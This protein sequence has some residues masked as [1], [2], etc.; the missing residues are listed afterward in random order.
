MGDEDTEEHE[1]EM[2]TLELS[3]SE[4]YSLDTILRYSMVDVEDP[5]YSEAA[6][7]LAREVHGTMASE[8]FN[9]AMDKQIDALIE[10]REKLQGEGFNHEP[11]I[12]GRGVQ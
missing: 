5:M 6:S 9:S 1:P 11:D 2:F 4:L 10:K 12:P 8:N 3:A 7:S